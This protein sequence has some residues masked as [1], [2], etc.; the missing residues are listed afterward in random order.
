MSRRGFTLLETALAAA[1]GGALVV[2]ALMMFMGMERTSR[3]LSVR[4]EQGS[5]LAKVRLVMQRATLS[6]LVA[7][8]PVRPRPSAT[9]ARPADPNAPPEPTPAE[10]ILTPRIILEADPRLA[11]LRM[12][13]RNDPEV[14]GVQRL[15]AV[16]MDSPVPESPRDFWGWAEGS[17]RRVDRTA[18]DA[19]GDPGPGVEE[20]L[21]D[22]AQAPVR[23]VRGA[24]EFWPQIG[25]GAQRD[26]EAIRELD[27]WSVEKPLLWE[28]W[29][30]PL[31]PRGEYLDD[32]PPPPL[33]LGD[34]YLI[35]RN[36]RYAR[37]TFFDDREHKVAFETALRQG[38]PAYVELE[39]ETGAGL[40]AQFMFETDWAIGPETARPLPPPG[41]PEGSG[42]GSGTGGGG[43]L[44][45]GGGGGGAG[46]GG[47]KDDAKGGGSGGG[48]G[49]KGGGK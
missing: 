7:P 45:T 23:A 9:P 42:R 8:N 37:W 47:G 40:R 46:T 28:L 18:R 20:A 15:E 13:R 49:G 22:E 6:F 44:G 36:I 29:W 24:F 31:Q 30:V 11:G 35:A 48:G 16:L 3:L 2:I 32:P 17:T 10:R 26:L 34:A 27:G 33:V 25:R 1:I 43:P 5:D 14:Y 41:S 38:L 39:V 4:A 19:G 12:T 21:A